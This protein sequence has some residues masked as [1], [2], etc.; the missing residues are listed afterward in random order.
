MVLRFLVSDSTVLFRSQGCEASHV[1]VIEFCFFC[2]CVGPLRITALSSFSF[3]P[4]MFYVHPV[5]FIPFL[6]FFGFVCCQGLHLVFLGLVV[7]FVVLPCNVIR[8]IRDLP[9]I[10]SVGAIGKRILP[11]NIDDQFWYPH[12]ILCSWGS[13]KA[14]HV[15]LA[16]LAVLEG[17][18]LSISL[19]ACKA[20]AKWRSRCLSLNDN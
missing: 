12:N 20:L 2:Y 16:E 10:H 17:E 4:E 14:G 3:T 9:R 5:I 15:Q 6:S 11:K 19:L 1:F 7:Y 13:L 8:I 18:N